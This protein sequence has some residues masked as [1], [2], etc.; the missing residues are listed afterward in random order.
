MRPRQRSQRLK[1]SIL[2]SL[3]IKPLSFLIPIITVPLFLK[4]L[5]T[6][7]FGLYNA[8]GA[9]ALWVGILNVGLNLGLIN[10]LTE[11]SIRDDRESARRYV[12]TLMLALAG[13]ILI[14]TAIWTVIV[15]SVNWHAV[16]DAKDPAVAR[17]TPLAVWTAGVAMLVGMMSGLPN[18]IYSGYQEIHRWNLWDGAATS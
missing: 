10:L 5:G 8:V 15:L 18:S 9:L 13:M 3:L 2:T 11:C 17:Q 1:L 7:G 12:S 4:Y 14:G 6:E 16:F